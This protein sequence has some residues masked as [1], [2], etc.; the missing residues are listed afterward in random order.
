LRYATDGTFSLLSRN[1]TDAGRLRALFSCAGFL[2]DEG[3]CFF[4]KCARDWMVV[5]FCSD[6]GE[7]PM[8]SCSLSEEYVLFRECFDE[9]L[10]FLPDLLQLFDFFDL[11]LRGVGDW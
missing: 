11:F 9:D 5:S 7:L 6:D 1:A 8:D 4:L 3:D 2:L 10:S